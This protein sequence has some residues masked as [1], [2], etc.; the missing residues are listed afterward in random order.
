MMF[1]A[2]WIGWLVYFIVVEAVAIYRT[3]KG[4]TLSEHVWLWFGAGKHHK[5]GLW[6]W[7]RR[8]ILTGFLVW[9]TVHFL[10]GV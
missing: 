10:F 2:L 9:L 3:T 6:G 8:L 7:V 4:D 5:P 1:T